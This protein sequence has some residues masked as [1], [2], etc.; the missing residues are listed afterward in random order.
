MAVPIVCVCVCVNVYVYIIP[1][2]NF[3][4]PVELWPNADHGLLILEVEC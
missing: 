2:I 3:L 4:F 1:T